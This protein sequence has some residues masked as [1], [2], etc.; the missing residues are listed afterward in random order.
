MK[1]KRE[2]FKT[3]IGMLL[4]CVGSAMGLANIWMFPARLAEF[5][6]LTFL[7]P[8]LLFLFGFSVFALMGEYA[9]GRKMRKGPVRAFEVVIAEKTTHP[10]L[11]AAGWFPVAALIGILSF[12][13]VIIGWILRYL[14]LAVSNAFT[15]MDVSFFESFAGTAANIPWTLAAL[16]ATAVIVSLGI[17][18]G[19]E[20]F[21][22]VMMAVFYI[23]VTTMVIRALT[24]PGALHG[25]AAMLQPKWEMLTHFRIWI[26]ALGMAFF[27]L[28]L[29]GAAMLVYGSYM[30]ETTDIPR[31]ARRTAALDFLASMLCA[32]FTVPAA[33]S[34][35]INPQ[36]GAAL[37]FIA[38]PQIIVRVPAGYLFGILFFLCALFAAFT[39]SIV[40][41]EVPVESLMSKYRLSRRKAAV[42]VS[43]LAACIAV[44]LNFDITVFTVFTDTVAIIVFPLAAV[45]AAVIIFWVY[46]SKKALDH[47]NFHAAHK[48]GSWYAPYMQ[49]IFV[50][51]CLLLVIAGIFLGGL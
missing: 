31:T 40:M 21:T 17:Q 42:I 45:T 50:P 6:G 2:L 8:Y 16:T 26:Y 4:A 9:F 48:I 33:Y 30:P 43:L 41:L 36:A 44:P 49:Y 19:I 3:N 1:Q 14:V 51:V 10:L 25:V 5:G 32:L 15:T 37:L 39:S 11:R 47:I 12:Y 23:V 27:T 7:I 24:L 38:V 46:G 28:S 20:R 29:G 34:L 13:T 18:K 22:T 35:G